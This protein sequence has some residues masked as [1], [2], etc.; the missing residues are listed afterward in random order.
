MVAYYYARKSVGV[1]ILYTNGCYVDDIRVWTFFKF[2]GKY[3]LYCF[4]FQ[5][6]FRVLLFFYF[7]CT[8]LCTMFIK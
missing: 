6:K 5:T 7:T 8:D 3:K 1:V 4:F 2:A